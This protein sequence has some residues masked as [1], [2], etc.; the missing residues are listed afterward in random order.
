MKRNVLIFTLFMTCFMTVTAQPQFPFTANPAN[1]VLEH[2][3][4]GAWD[5][6][7]MISPNIVFDNGTYYLFYTG[8]ETSGQGAIGY[9]ISSDGYN[10]TKVTVSDPVFASDGTGFDAWLVSDPVI[11][12][13]GNQWVMYYGARQYAG[14]GP[15]P[16]IGKA[17]ANDL[18][19]PWVRQDDPI[20]TVGIAGEWDSHFITP[21]S[22][23]T[24]D[25]ALLMYYAGGAS[26]TGN[27]YVGL[28][29][30][31][32]SGWVKYDNPSTTSPPY[33]QS[34]PVLT[35]GAT[36]S[37]D[38]EIATFGF[39]KQVASGYEM[40]Y[41]GSGWGN[42]AI[43]YATSMDGV[44]WQ[45][46]PS[47]P[48]YTYLDDPFAVNQGYDHIQLPSVF[49][50]NDEYLIFYDYALVD[51][52]IGMATAPTL[53]QIIHVPADQPTIQAGIDIATT[54]DTVLVAEGTYYEN[55]NFLGK[56]ITVASHFIMD[57]DTNHIN[58][59][60]ID[61]SQPAHPDSASV[62]YFIS[63]EDT[64]SVI[65]GF[66]ITGGNG[67]IETSY[68]VRAGGGIYAY[69]SSC[70]IEYN[71]IT[72]NHV[73]GYKAG[74]AGLLCLT[75]DNQ[76]RWAI[77]DHNTI[78]YNTSTSDGFSAFGGGM[79]VLIN[80]IITNN[81]IEYNACTNIEGSADGGGIE[82]EQMPGTGIS[83]LIQN[84]TIRNNELEGNICSGAGI[85]ILSISTDN[86]SILDNTISSNNILCSNSGFGDGCGI[87]I[88]KNSTPVL[89]KNNEISD[90]EIVS[91]DW[92]RGGG[93][94]FWEP[95]AKVD[96]IN[97]NI[98]DNVIQ[99]MNNRGPGIWF[100]YPSGDV[101]VIDNL[102]QG[103]TGPV[104]NVQ[105]AAGGGLCVLD[106]TGKVTIDRNRFIENQ[107]YNG[108]GLYIRRS[109]NSAI[110][111][112][113]FVGNYAS[114]GAALCFY[115]PAKKDSDGR[116]S[117]NDITTVI[118]NTITQS[119]ALEHG[120]GV[121][122][123]GLT[124]APHFYNCIF[125]DNTASIGSDLCNLMNTDIPL[126]YSAINPDHVSGGWTGEGNIN[127]DPLFDLSGPHPYALMPNSPC[128]DTGTPDTTGLC[129]PVCDI[130]GC[131]RI[132][133]GDGDSIAVIDM[134][135][136]E[137]GAPLFVG[138]P[139]S[140]IQNPKSE[141]SAYPNPFHSSTTIEFELKAKTQATLQVYN[142]MGQLVAELLNES[143]APG[144]HQLS[145]KPAHL[146]P[147]LYFFRLQAGNEV[148]TGKVI[149]Q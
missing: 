142:H 30:N 119:T 69:N 31:S 56:A 110:T 73:E 112:N 103:N 18:A 99:G 8:F 148:R 98:Q 104:D 19:G 122:L 11:I 137:F 35:T 128:I 109:L 58:N 115:Y 40:F 24:T 143:R 100:R 139:Q 66:T 127:E 61:G 138:I 140:E 6:G 129:L 92:A 64:T 4:P 74:G 125:W 20:L 118:N 49:I 22:V 134:G 51:G 86:A 29:C 57:A 43:G 120:G 26:L 14:P 54:G 91:D 21:T 76:N 113:L 27:W 94:A 132:W 12:K 47:N 9:A 1:P 23:I 149:K 3:A 34:D 84:N 117:R 5:A 42:M 147:G 71:R 131:C 70:R 53:P 96:I 123:S 33:S 93:I 105:S 65:K 67:T 28:A 101:S 41:S 126:N 25:T 106:A 121:Y 60:I 89:V 111:N 68:N 44:E 15:G 2:G 144:Q 10:F 52:Y 16:S 145:W 38:S 80:S 124:Y 95:S 37:W 146:P 39:V 17:T 48:V 87:F 90:N 81:T 75:L 45:K 108:G 114:R 7:G 46:H 107:M 133:D 83:T 79:S 32:G 88:Y 78:N 36:G 63:G 62:V 77:I 97:N 130:I 136:Y 59:T 116:Y 141:I 85:S 72:S 102:F 55:I 50:T 13:E 135:A 82:I